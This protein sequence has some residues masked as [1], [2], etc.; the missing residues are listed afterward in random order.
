MIS[1]SVCVVMLVVAVLLMAA[2]VASPLGL[3]VK[4]VLLAIQG[5]VAVLQIWLLRQ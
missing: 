1:P 2:T 5:S 4:G 3:P